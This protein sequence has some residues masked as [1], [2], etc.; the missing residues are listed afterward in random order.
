MISISK[1]PYKR[2]RIFLNPQ[3]FLSGFKN[4]HVHTY[5]VNSTYESVTF[6]ICSGSPEWKFLN[7]L[8]IRNR[9]DAKSG[10]LTLIGRSW[11]KY[12]DLSVASRSIICRSRRL[13]QKNLS[14]RHW[15]ITIF[16]DNRYRFNNCFIIR[17]P[18]L[19]FFNYSPKNL[20]FSH[21]NDGK[22]E[23][24]V[25]SFTHEQNII[26][27]QTQLDDIAHEQTINYF[28]AVICRSRGELS[29]NE[30]EEKFASNDNLFYPVT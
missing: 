29:S 7:T 25:D 19:F 30:K 5:P 28:W 2:I 27:S 20:P 14:V 4:L 6:L 12:R 11:A 15:Q 22:K 3:L 8:W 21:K 10:Y 13:S 17:W 23:K 18:S 9:V 24:S 1:V 16:C 26:C